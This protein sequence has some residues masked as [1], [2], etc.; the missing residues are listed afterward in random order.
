MFMKSPTHSSI[1]A[2]D[3]PNSDD[4]WAVDRFEPTIPG[5]CWQPVSSRDSKTRG[6]T[7]MP[8]T[9]SSQSLLASLPSF[10]SVF[11][12][13]QGVR[14]ERKDNIAT[15]NAT[16]RASSTLNGRPIHNNPLPSYIFRRQSFSTS[17]SESTESS[18]TTTI[19]T[20]DSSLT[21]P[22]PSSSPESPT[23]LIPLSS[24]RFLKTFSP[25]AK[26]TSMDE[27]NTPPSPL[28]N[29]PGFNRADSP[30]KK[31]RNTKNL[32]LN[33]TAS[34]SSIPPLPRLGMPNSSTTAPSH[35]S[36]VPTTPSFA[37]P[38][39]PPKRKPS[40]LGLTITTAETMSTS[41]SPQVAPYLAPETP[42]EARP[43]ALKHYPTMPS[44]PLSVFS[45]TAAPPGG[46]KLPPL[47]NTSTTGRFPKPRQ[48]LNTTQ[49][50]S[51]DS[52][53]SSP[54]TIQTLEHVPEETSYELPLSREMKSPAYPAGPVCIYDPHVFLYLEPSH[55]EASRY[56]VIIN[57]AREVV[58]PFIAAADKTEG[59][60][61]E[62]AAVQVN[63]VPE[64]NVTGTHASV[65]EFPSAVSETSSRSAFEELPEHGVDRTAKFS[66]PINPSPEYIHMPWDHNS[67]VVDDFHKL[68]EIIDDRSQQGK[69]VLVHCQCGVSRS[70]S[71][72]I[73]YG[74]YK[75]P[76]LTVQEAYDA[77]KERSQWIGPNMHL[78]YQLA[79]YKSI[80][81]RGI[82]PVVSRRSKRNLGPIRAN[83][84]S[85]LN[86]DTISSLPSSS[87]DSQMHPST[88]P[89]KDNHEHEPPRSNSLSPSSL[90]QTTATMSTG[91]VSPGP[92]SAPPEMHWSPTSS[93]PEVREESDRPDSDKNISLPISVPS[94]NVKDV[95]IFDASPSSTIQNRL[96]E[97]Q[98]S[99]LQKLLT[100][101]RS[102]QLPGGFSSIL[103][104]RQAL[105]P[106]PLRQEVS[107]CSGIQLNNMGADQIM[108]DDVLGTPSL[109]SPRAAEFT[110][111][112]FHRTAAG[113]LAGSSVFEQA[114][115]SPRILDADPRSPHQI[116]EAPITRSIDNI[117]D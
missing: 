89:L 76:Q 91:S 85:F 105:R 115:M 97:R 75:N 18:P 72:V 44:I 49:H 37:I 24:F 26:A 58:N 98:T 113:D 109:L 19:S 52:S 16:G 110:A 68:C 12:E 50:F 80:V 22:S 92:S 15:N 87:E 96:E 102:H 45:P 103:V 1:V 30:N 106:L 78:I 69:R 73:A 23:S 82:L 81:A 77:V 39:K 31:M 51:Y 59:H 88:A 95:E 32:S 9:T 41:Q 74:L 84:D 40:S 17:Q 99:S 35:P 67:N 60:R 8:V 43:S 104:R 94:S 13:G 7:R 108:T 93:S 27:D 6:E 14:E 54:T 38:A 25:V 34:S 29:L 56:D 5:G 116:G 42:V 111:S 90:A 20:V 114:L 48:T 100:P 64:G 21:E 65:P 10:M 66:A 11:G 55:A 2:E 28:M 83:R 107:R 53:R 33:T 47:G 62:D 3:R 61:S 46:M 57:V 71:L 4:C 86:T 117:L 70:A 63:F 101:T 36:S 112:P 79:E